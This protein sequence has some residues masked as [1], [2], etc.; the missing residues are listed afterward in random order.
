MIS[1]LDVHLTIFE[2]PARVRKISSNTSFE[3]TLTTFTSKNTV[4]LSRRFIA[5]NHAFNRRF[6][7]SGAFV[8][9]WAVLWRIKLVFKKNGRVAVRVVK[10]S[11]R[12]WLLWQASQSIYVYVK[13]WGRLIGKRVHDKL[14]LGVTEPPTG[15]V[16]PSLNTN[17]NVYCWTIKGNSELRTK[18]ISR[19][20]VNYTI[21]TRLPVIA[22]I[23]FCRKVENSFSRQCKIKLT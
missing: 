19:L 13:S 23:V 2:P 1:V 10:L 21:F 14:E 5:A 22:N 17:M 4:M 7:C 18:A 6:W 12:A 11:A 20:C 3:E 16:D 15:G 8:V 9:F